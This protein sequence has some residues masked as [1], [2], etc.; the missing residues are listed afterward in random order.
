MAD[1]NMDLGRTSPSLPK[2]PTSA[3]TPLVQ[4]AKNRVKRPNTLLLSGY[5]DNDDDDRRGHRAD[6]K[7]ALLLSPLSDESLL[8]ADPD[9]A[10]ANV[11]HPVQVN[12]QPVV[13]QVA[14]H[15]YENTIIFMA[16]HL[17][18]NPISFLTPNSKLI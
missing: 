18:R 11:E 6:Q 16:K 17:V 4:S 12:G 9:V 3:T 8:S 10:A 15:K 14:K 7:D 5:K 13:I 1:Q 2:L